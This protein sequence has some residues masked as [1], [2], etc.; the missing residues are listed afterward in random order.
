MAQALPS[1][2]STYSEGARTEMRSSPGWLSW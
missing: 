1:G 2:A